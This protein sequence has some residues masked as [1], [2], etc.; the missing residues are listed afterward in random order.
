MTKRWKKER[1]RERKEYRKRNDDEIVRDE[2]HRYEVNEGKF[3]AGNP[4]ENVKEWREWERERESN[5]DD[6]RKGREDKREN[7]KLRERIDRNKECKIDETIR[8]TKYQLLY[9][10]KKI[11]CYFLILK[12]FHR[13]FFKSSTLFFSSLSLI[14]SSNI[15]ILQCSPW[16]FIS[17]YIF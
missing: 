11:Q 2:N 14:Y 4:I 8:N 6:K 3:R 1:E 5:A 15:Y 17:W 10:K 7:D 16:K 9:S 12:Q 13:Y